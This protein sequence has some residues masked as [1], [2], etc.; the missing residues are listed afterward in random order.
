[1]RHDGLFKNFWLKTPESGVFKQKFLAARQ[2]QNT[3]SWQTVSDFVVKY[4]P[5]S[6][7]EGKIQL[8][9]EKIAIENKGSYDYQHFKF[10]KTL[11]ATS[12]ARLS[13]LQELTFTL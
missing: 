13:V 12:P 6:H 2:F 11:H 5:L 7:L 1:M 3:P 8:K 9:K 10:E 4:L